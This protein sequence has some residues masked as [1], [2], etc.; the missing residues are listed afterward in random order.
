MTSEA[1]GADFVVILTTAPSQEVALALAE[2]LVEERLVACANLVPGLLSVY[3]W[4]G[5][6]VREAEVLVVMKTH[7]DRRDEVFDRVAELHPYEVPELLALPAEAVSE[8]YGR[9]LRRE[10]TEVSR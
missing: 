3:R 8:A 7:R 6:R 9:W 5:E 10:T 1:P 4:E 2:A